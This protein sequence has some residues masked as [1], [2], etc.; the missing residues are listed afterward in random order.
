MNNKNLE[1]TILKV[2]LRT[3]STLRKRKPEIMNDV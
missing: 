3:C 2:L 1:E